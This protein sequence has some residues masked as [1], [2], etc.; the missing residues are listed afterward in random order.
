[1]MYVCMMYVCV[2]DVHMYVLS[3]VYF[4]LY[5]DRHTLYIDRHTLI[6]AN[7]CSEIEAL[8]HDIK[9][10]FDADQVILTLST[11]PA[12]SFGPT[13][14]SAE[15]MEWESRTGLCGN[16]GYAILS[17]HVVDAGRKLM[18]VFGCLLCGVFVVCCVGVFL[19]SLHTLLE[20]LNN[21]QTMIL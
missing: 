6:N 7:S 14:D 9:S 11:P 2:C 1:M 20:R 21:K 19:S 17:L 15:R 10:M 3:D 12:L 4:E 16:H 18:K 5:I 13:K 8:F